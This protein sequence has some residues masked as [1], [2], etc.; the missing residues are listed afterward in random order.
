[1]ARCEGHVRRYLYSCLFGEGTFVGTFVPF[2]GGRIA[3]RGVRYVFCVGLKKEEQRKRGR[4]EPSSLRF[5]VMDSLPFYM[6]KSS[7][8]VVVRAKS[9][10]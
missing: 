1:M 5:R 7:A 8:T 3:E 2:W 4:R 6:P 10:Q 9:T